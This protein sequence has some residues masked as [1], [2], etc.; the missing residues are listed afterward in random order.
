MRSTYFKLVATAG[1]ALAVS[2]CA[3]TDPATG[4]TSKSLI[5]VA[6]GQVSNVERVKMDVNYAKGAAVGGG[7]GLL[8]TSRRSRSSQ[9]GGALAGAAIGALVQKAAAGDGMANKF[10]VN[11][12]N[13]NTVAIITEQGDIDIGD[14]VS[15]EQGKQA[16]IRRV[17][18]VMCQSDTANHPAVRNADMEEA[19][20]CLTAKQEVMQAETE[21]A[22]D[23]AYRKMRAFCDQ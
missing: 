3:T 9:I 22:V 6:Y 20:E 5:S 19:Q 18:S 2:G 14:C 17:S 15:V 21:Q 11:L 10:T 23:V 7:L 13:G 16:N 12:S 8:A 1:M 4:S